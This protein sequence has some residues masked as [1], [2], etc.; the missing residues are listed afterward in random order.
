MFYK[1]NFSSSVKSWKWQ[2][3]TSAMSRCKSSFTV[4]IEIQ[5]KQPFAIYARH[6][7]SLILPTILFLS[8]SFLKYLDNTTVLRYYHKK[9]KQ[10]F[11]I[12]KLELTLVQGVKLKASP[13]YFLM[14]QQK[15][16]KHALLCNQGR[17]SKP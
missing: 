5:K 17:V 12:L 16:S 3:I 6:I 2:V 13:K 9:S 4:F 14:S 8:F 7:S 10:C 11:V 1:S 15:K